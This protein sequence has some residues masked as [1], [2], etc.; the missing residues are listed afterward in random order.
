[1][2]TEQGLYAQLVVISRKGLKLTEANK[3][4]N[5]A[6]FKFQGQSE[7]SQRCF[8]IDFDWIEVHFITRELDLYRKTLQR[9]D[10]TQDT[11]TF[12]IFEVPIGYSKCVEN[13]SFTVKPQCSSIFKSH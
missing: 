4:K 7:R 10:K 13:L 5:E 9:H 1:M 8:R 6:K 12:Q 11:N 2:A 3:N